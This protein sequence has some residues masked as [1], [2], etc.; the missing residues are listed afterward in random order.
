MTNSSFC[1]LGLGTR[2]EFVFVARNKKKTEWTSLDMER[3][4][5]SAINSYLVQLSFHYSK[6]Y[7]VKLDHKELLFSF[8]S[9]TTFSM[10]VLWPQIK[11]LHVCVWRIN[12]SW[13]TEHVQA[14]CF[15]SSRRK[16]SQNM[17]QHK[18]TPPLHIP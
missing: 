3:E 8:F 12:L 2:S 6:Q 16:I 13:K 15:P 9:Q 4:V 1:Q 7:Y 10:I 18:L 17:L 11:L 5:H 14:I